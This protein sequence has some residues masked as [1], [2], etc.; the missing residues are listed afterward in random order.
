[1]VKSTSTNRQQIKMIWVNRRLW[2]IYGLDNIFI[3][4]HAR[5]RIC[6]WIYINEHLARTS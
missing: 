1:M 6:H 5:G 3:S 2:D 4:T